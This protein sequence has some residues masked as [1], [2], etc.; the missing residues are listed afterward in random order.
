MIVKDVK[1]C[2]VYFGSKSLEWNEYFCQDVPRKMRDGARLHSLWYHV[3][4][5]E[6]EWVR[7]TSIM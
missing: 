4:T 5:Q 3:P 1:A 2:Y 7:Q 6:Q